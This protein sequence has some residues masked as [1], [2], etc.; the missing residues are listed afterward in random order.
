M[1]QFFDI[2]GV[3]QRHLVVESSNRELEDRLGNLDSIVDDLGEVIRLIY[4]IIQRSGLLRHDEI[5]E[6]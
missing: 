6:V 5:D 4:L 3:D 2:A 1:D